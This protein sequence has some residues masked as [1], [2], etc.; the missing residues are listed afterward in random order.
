M[1]PVRLQPEAAAELAEAAAWYEAQ[2]PGLGSSLLDE[3]ERLLPA[4][5]ERPSAFAR[6][7]D[8]AP[9]LGLRR[10]LLPRFPFGVVF[11]QTAEE[12]RIVAVAHAKR[13]PGYWLH[14]VL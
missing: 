7:I 5:G 6:L 9:D 12:I 1:R 8:T 3:V 13:Q 10:A 14:R 2:Q 4:L 11:L